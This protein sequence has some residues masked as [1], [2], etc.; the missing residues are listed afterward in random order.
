MDLKGVGLGQF[1]KVSGYVQQA[2]KIGQD[3][4]PETMGKLF[5]LNPPWL[6]NTVWSVIKGY[7]DPATVEKIH[8]LTDEK[9]LLEHVSP[10]NLPT[11][12]GGKCDCH[13]K[14][15]CMAS[16]AGPWNTEQ[17]KEI[18]EKVR[19]EEAAKKEQHEKE[20]SQT[21]GTK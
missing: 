18:I 10:E 8:I 11:L 7:L 17:G 5:V 1:W 20:G 19:K 2:S 9:Q 6:F 13:G 21:N 12:V 16:D 15:G 3:Y 14:G 4:Y